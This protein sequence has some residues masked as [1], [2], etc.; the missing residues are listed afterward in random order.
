MRVTCTALFL[1]AGPLLHGQP[2]AID[3]S[4][5]T[6]TVHVY[7]AGVLSALGHDHEITAPLAAGSVD[8]AARKVELRVDA[9]ALRVQDAKTSDKDRAE[10]QANM[11]GAD[12]LNADAYKEIRFRSTSAAPAGQG[13]WKVSG[14]LTIRDHTHP[15]SMEV[16]AADGRFTGSCRVSIADFGIKPIRAGGGT[17]RVKDEIQIDFDIQLAR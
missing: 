9:G 12:V 2:R 10:V 6:M 17:V 13:V 5:S 8:I 3:A 15:V 7:K 11:L 1:L 4:H 14:D 16:H